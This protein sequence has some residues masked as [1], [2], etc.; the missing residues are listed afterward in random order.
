MEKGIVANPLS[1]S[2][3][4]KIAV[5]NRKHVLLP[6]MVTD[7]CVMSNREKSAF[8]FLRTLYR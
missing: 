1:R 2:Y 4:V 5:E 7:V 3:E 8:C 6:G